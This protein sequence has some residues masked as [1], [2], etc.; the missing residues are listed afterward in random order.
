MATMAMIPTARKLPYKSGAP[1]AIRIPLQ[2]K[3]EN[4]SK[5]NDPPIKPSSSAKMA[6]IKSVCGSGK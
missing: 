4:N 5:M 1:K 2:S 6:N 3:S